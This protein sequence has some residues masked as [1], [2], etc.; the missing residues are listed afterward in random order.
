MFIPDRVAAVI[1]RLWPHTTKDAITSTVSFSGLG[2]D[3]LMVRELF[4]SSEEE[5]GIEIPDEEADRFRTVGDLIRYAEEWR[6]PAG[7]S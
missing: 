6:E 4:S 7:R 2:L 5:I 3:S 1:M